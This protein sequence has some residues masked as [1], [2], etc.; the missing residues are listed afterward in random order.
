MLSLACGMK[1]IGKVEDICPYCSTRL[2]KRPQR[3]AKCPHCRKFIFVRT[4]PTDRKRVLVTESQV[5]EIETQWNEIQSIPAP[6]I[7]KKEGFDDE[8]KKLTQKFDL[9]PLHNDVVWSLLNKDLIEHARSR[10]WGLYRNTLF[11]MGEL[12]RSESKWPDALSKYFEVCYFDL[13]GPT[14]YGDISDIDPELLRLAI[15]N[16]LLPFDPAEGELFPDVLT[17]VEYLVK[18]LQ[19]DSGMVRRQFLAVAA[20]LETALRLPMRPDAAWKSMKDALS[21]T[22]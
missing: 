1:D 12:L 20:K 4:R 16:R 8:K 7:E 22:L 19:L 11:E 21:G 9:E 18:H 14:N 15:G 3:K 2:S 17:R 13:N 5:K 10:H 6:R